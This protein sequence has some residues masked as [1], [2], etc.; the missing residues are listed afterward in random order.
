[1]REAY[2]SQLPDHDAAHLMQCLHTSVGEGVEGGRG[3]GASK[4][5]CPIMVREAVS[6]RTAAPAH[7]EGAGNQHAYIW[8]E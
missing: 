6:L 2:G 8:G 5:S 3:E 1:M 4:A 7:M